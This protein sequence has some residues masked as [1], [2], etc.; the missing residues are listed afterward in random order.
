RFLSTDPVYGGNANAYDYTYADPINKY[1]LDGRRWGWIKPAWQRAKQAWNGLK[2]GWGRAQS[3]WYTA[4]RLYRP[5]RNGIAYAWKNRWK[6]VD[7]MRAYQSRGS[8]IGASYGASQCAGSPLWMC[9]GFISVGSQ[10]GS[11]AGLGYGWARWGVTTIRSWWKR[12]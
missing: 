8:F 12:R 4:R 11:T 1:D 5:A 7:N 9:I 6:A 10:V 2:R 3:A